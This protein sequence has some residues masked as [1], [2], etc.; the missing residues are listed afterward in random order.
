M[1]IELMRCR[2]N[3]MIPLLY[4]ETTFHFRDSASVSTLAHA[5]LPAHLNTIRSLSIEWDITDVHLPSSNG[6]WKRI[7]DMATGMERIGEVRLIV[8]ASTRPHWHEEFQWKWKHEGIAKRIEAGELKVDFWNFGKRVEAI[9]GKDERRDLP[10][11]YS[12][13]QWGPEWYEC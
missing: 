7:W 2:Y 8:V 11:T 3:E 5:L 9:F 1:G 6:K 12:P 10:S 4:S 13:V